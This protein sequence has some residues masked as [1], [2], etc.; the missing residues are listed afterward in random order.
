MRVYQMADDATWD[1]MFGSLS[2]NS[3]AMCLT[4]SQIIAYCE[5]NRDKLRTN[6]DGTFFLLKSGSNLFVTDLDPHVG[7]PSV[8]LYRF[9]RSRICH[10]V[11]RHHLVVAETI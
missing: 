6:R 1:Q 5:M 4:E 10:G 3:D 8:Q 11:G 7:K 9:A 2:Q